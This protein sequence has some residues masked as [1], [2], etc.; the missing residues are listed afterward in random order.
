MGELGYTGN[1]GSLTG[2]NKKLVKETIQAFS[3]DRE[4]M[5]KIEEF[6]KA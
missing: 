5:Q 2:K 1:I 3:D 4:F 6:I